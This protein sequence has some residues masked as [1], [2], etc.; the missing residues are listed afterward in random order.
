ML[1]ILVTRRHG[2]KKWVECG[3]EQRVEKMAKLFDEVVRED[4]Y[5]ALAYIESDARSLFC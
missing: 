2:V 4:F 5:I 1:K 3:V